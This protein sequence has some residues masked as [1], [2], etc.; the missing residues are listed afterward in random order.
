[1]RNGRLYSLYESGR[2]IYKKVITALRASEVLET[3]PAKCGECNKRGR[4]GPVSQ[5]VEESSAKCAR[6]L[7][8]ARYIVRLLYG[9]SRKPEPNSVADGDPKRKAPHSGGCNGTAMA[10]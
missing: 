6:R 5:Y 9:R 1:M 8:N 10:G 7:T 3:F 2:F 4:V